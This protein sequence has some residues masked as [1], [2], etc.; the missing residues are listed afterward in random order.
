[1]E[2]YRTC[3]ENY[4]KVEQ[5]TLDRSIFMPVFERFL[6]GKVSR[7]TRYAILTCP[8]AQAAFKAQ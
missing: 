4:L 5:P 6:T 1:M 8:K 7:T 3:C 2:D